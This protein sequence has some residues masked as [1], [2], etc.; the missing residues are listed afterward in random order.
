MFHT[1]V[2]STVG[3]SCEFARFWITPMS[4][5]PRFNKFCVANALNFFFTASPDSFVVRAHG[6]AIFSSYA[7][8]PAIHDLIITR[9]TIRLG[10]SSYWL[11]HSTGVA[12]AE[13]SRL[14]IRL[15]RIYNF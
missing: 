12:A 4:L 13:V 14:L 9:G 6:G 15:Q 10:S 8:S 11:H 7:S 5:S 2:A 1:M 3:G